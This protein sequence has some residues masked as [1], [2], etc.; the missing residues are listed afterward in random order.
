MTAQSVTVRLFAVLRERAGTAEIVIAIEEGWTVAEVLGRVFE[1]H[2]Q[3]RS[4]DAFL[5]TAVNARYAARGT[6][7]TDGDEVALISPVSGG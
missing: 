6:T 3:L 7:V 2:P 1:R 5:R 4:F